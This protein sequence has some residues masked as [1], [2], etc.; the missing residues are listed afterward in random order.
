M[1]AKKGHIFKIILTEASMLSALG[2]IAGIALGGSGLYIFKGFIRSSLSIPYLWPSPLEYG[3][4]IAFCFMLSMLTGL[5]AVLY[6]A[7]KSM[8]MEPYSAIRRGE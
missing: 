1:G 7:T 8:L 4:L 5:I 2:G 6:P 3:L